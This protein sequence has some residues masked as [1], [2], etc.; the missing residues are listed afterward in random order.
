MIKK[1]AKHV[2]ICIPATKEDNMSESLWALEVAPGCV[3]VDNITLS[4]DL[5]FCGIA[6]INDEHNVVEILYEGWPQDILQYENNGDAEDE[7][8][9]TL[10]A[11]IVNALRAHGVITEG[12]T[13]GWLSV[14]RPP[15]MTDAVL[16]RIVSKLPGRVTWPTKQGVTDGR[17]SVSG[18]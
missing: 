9:K 3:V 10:Y 7:F 6:C 11:Q 18:V 1:K 15:T 5:R 17:E 16:E 14:A 8:T 4:T 2:K 12:M 13:L